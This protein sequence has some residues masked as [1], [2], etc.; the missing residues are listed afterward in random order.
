MKITVAEARLLKNSVSK[1]LQD[2]LRERNQIAYIEFEKGEDYTPHARTF[3]EVTND[4]AKVRGHYRAVKKGLSESNLHTTI[5]W[6]GEELTLVEALELVK[7]LRSE[8]DSL[9]MFGNS[10]QVERISRGAFEAKVSFKKALFEPPVVKKDGERLLKEANRLSILIDKANFNAM[11]E[12][13]FV[14]EYQ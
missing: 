7:E 11:V 3:Q 4:I 10:Q 2:L 8:A 13:D 9:K 1:K 6:Q 5:Q 14:D 12:F